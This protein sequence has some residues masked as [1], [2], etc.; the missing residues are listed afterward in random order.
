LT[1]AG[2]VFMAIA[3]T[4]VLGLAGFCVSRTLRER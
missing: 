3:W 1:L 4:L 2:W